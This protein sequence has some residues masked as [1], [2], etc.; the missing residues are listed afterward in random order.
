LIRR[1]KP[2]LPEAVDFVVVVQRPARLATIVENGG[3]VPAHFHQ[4]ANVRRAE[5]FNFCQRIYPCKKKNEI[6]TKLF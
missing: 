6:N 1:K 3:E 5:I 2:A 4:F